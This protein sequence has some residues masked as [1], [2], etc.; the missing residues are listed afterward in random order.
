[1]GQTLMQSSKTVTANLVSLPQDADKQLPAIVQSAP[2][3]P[4]SAKMFCPKT[5]FDALINAAK[6]CPGCE[7]FRGLSELSEYADLT[8][9][10][11]PPHLRY[12]IRCVHPV[13]RR[14]NIVHKD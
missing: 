11:V 13:D 8:L 4:S 12:R 7:H 2:E 9:D 5:G 1:M 14:F 3:I 10:S 6:R